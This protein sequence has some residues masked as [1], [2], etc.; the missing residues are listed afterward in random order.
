MGKARET[1][2]KAA[3][4]GTVRRDNLVVASMVASFLD[5]VDLKPN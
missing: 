1:T 3:D 5:D 2:T 4:K